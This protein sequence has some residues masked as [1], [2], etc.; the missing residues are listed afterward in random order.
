[1]KKALI[2][3]AAF[4]L[5]R[6]VVGALVP[7]AWHLVTGIDVSQLSA[8]G[9]V[10]VTTMALF[11]LVSIVVFLW[12]RW[13]V[14][15]PHWIRTRPWLVLLWSALAAVGAVIPSAFLQEQMPE[16]P[17]WAGEG[18]ESI[19]NDRLGYF[20]VGLLAPFCE[21]LVFR[22]AILRVLL[23]WAR[24]PWVAILISAILFSLIHANPAQMPHA[25]IIGLLLGWMYYRT[26]SILPGVCYHWV[27]NSIAY[28]VTRLYPDPDLT[29]ADI[30]GTQQHVLMA[31]AFSLCIM[32]PSLF[33][34]NL[35]MRKE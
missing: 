13:A 26:G 6:L 5:F 16:L 15:S 3:V 21:E 19:M 1:M 29:L 28:V 9:P 20:C 27:N 24:R 17:D 10:L 31:V 34:L 18:L 32:L 25:F 8:N 33:Q 35:W 14:V 30:L 7:A 23:E 11:S 22:G 12:Q 4:L 2:Y